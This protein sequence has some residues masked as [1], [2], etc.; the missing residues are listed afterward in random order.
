[1]SDRVASQALGWRCDEPVG[2]SGAGTAPAMTRSTLARLV[3]GVTAAISLMTLG[4][5]L[6]Y[7][8]FGWYPGSEPDALTRVV[9]WFSYFTNV[10]NIL[11]VVGLSM[12]AGDPQ[13]DGRWFRPVRL[14][15]LVGITVTFLVYMV[16][17]RPDQVLD[18][19]HIWTNAGYHVAVPILA[20]AGWLVF[21]PFPR[22]DGRSLWL[23]LLL[24]AVWA[25]WTLLHGA[26]SGW[27]PYAIIDASTLGYPAALRTAAVILLLIAGVA[28]LYTWVDRVRFRRSAT[29][30]E[31]PMPH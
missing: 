29:S 1:M 19:I 11:C 4:I 8:V 13:R 26:V 16:A 24:V 7:A 18:G 27:Y 2:E 31:A 6:V 17:L 30:S 21:G 10:S 20:V 12:L 23:T 15:G 28:G 25:A 22:A 5:E 14:A 9:N 3:F